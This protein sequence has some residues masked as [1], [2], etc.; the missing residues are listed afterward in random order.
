ML[1]G[2]NLVVNGHTHNQAG[3]LW[4]EIPILTTKTIDYFVQQTLAIRMVHKV[5]NFV[6][7]KSFDGNEE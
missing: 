5:S 3:L 4:S 1:R 6:V 7:L 2:G